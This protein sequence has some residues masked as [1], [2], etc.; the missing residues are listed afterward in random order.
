[1]A[2]QVLG[3]NGSAIQQ[4]DPSHQAAHST[5]FPYEALAWGSIGAQS[6]ALTT[7][8]AAGGVFSLRNT[9]TNLIAIRRIGV[10]FIATTAFTTAQIVDYGLFIARGFT[11]ADS[12]GT[13]VVVSAS[14]NTKFRTS[15]AVPNIDARIA[16]TAALTVGTR[17]LDANSV[18]QIG[19]WSG[20]LGVGI[21]PTPNNL[22]THDTGDH[23]IILAANE[24]IVIENLTVMGAAGVGRL[25]VNIEFAELAAF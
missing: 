22:H 24:G 15:L 19:G 2:I 10:G 8:A 14:N 4:V 7:V 1:M 18:A 5:L 6:G 20:A 13:S 25:Y 9:S 23:P 17:T 21:A 11:A 12:G 16:T 3:A